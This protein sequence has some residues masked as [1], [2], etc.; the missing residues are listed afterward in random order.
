MDVLTS[1]PSIKYTVPLTKCRCICGQAVAGVDKYLGHCP[2]SH[3]CLMMPLTE[4]PSREIYKVTKKQQCK[5]KASEGSLALLYRLCV[6]NALAVQPSF[7]WLLC[8]RIQQINI[9]ATLRQTKTCIMAHVCTGRLVHFKMS[10]E[11]TWI[12]KLN[13]PVCNLY[14]QLFLLL[15]LLLWPLLL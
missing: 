9:H 10:G 12:R 4:V 6:R 11:I 7:I 15:F 3:T 8:L 13:F 5:L 2:W 14:Q 1:T